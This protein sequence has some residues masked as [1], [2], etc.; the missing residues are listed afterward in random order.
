MDQA[1]ETKFKISLTPHRDMVSAFDWVT[2]ECN[3]PTMS[4]CRVK[5]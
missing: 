1:T 5:L 2:I 3:R 4:R